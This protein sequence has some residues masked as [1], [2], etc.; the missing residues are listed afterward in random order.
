MAMRKVAI[1]IKDMQVLMAMVLQKEK[2][3]FITT[4]HFLIHE[5]FTKQMICK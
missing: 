1:Q 4:N 2:V 3:T 5:S